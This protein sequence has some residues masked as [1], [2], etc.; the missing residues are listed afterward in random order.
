MSDFPTHP[1]E[2]DLYLPDPTDG[3]SWDPMTI[4]THC[5]IVSVPDAA[6]SIFVY[7]RV[8]PAYGMSQ[9]GLSIFQGL[10]NPANDGGVAYVDYRETM[11]WPTVGERRF[12]TANGLGIEFVEPGRV[13][14]VTYTSP[15]GA[16]SLDVTQTAVTPLLARGHIIP[17]EDEDGDAS[18]SPGGSEQFMHNVG[19]LV[20]HGE[21]HVIDSHDCRDRSWRQVRSEAANAAGAP[22]VCWTPMHFGDDLTFN[23]VSIEHAR[24]NPWWTG[25]FEVPD[26]HPTHHF[27]WARVD[28]A[29]RRVTRVDRDVHEYHPTLLIPTRQTV[30]AE[31]ETGRTYRFEGEALA[32][33]AV[34]AWSNATLRQFLYRW[35]DADTGR[36]AANSGQEIWL[37]NRY[38]PHAARRAAA[39]VEA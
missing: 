22:P 14:R 18:L 3:T 37:D 24:T 27:A 8:L 1:P 25:L 38:A 9:G 32:A 20:L 11:P 21:R 29:M 10:D 4:C 19:E 23:Q 39:A 31:D 15:D 13:L 33:A 2:T 7:L 12:D 16:T 17:G 34:P 5:S 35:T 6:I 30:E 36:T 28:G 26:E